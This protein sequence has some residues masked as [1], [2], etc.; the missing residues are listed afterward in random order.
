MVRSAACYIVGSE[1]ELETIRGRIKAHTPPPEE[2]INLACEDVEI[3]TEITLE[4]GGR[5]ISGRMEK[6][7][8]KDKTFRG[9][10][11]QVPV[12]YTVDF[13]FVQLGQLYLIVHAGRKIADEIAEELESIIF[14]GMNGIVKRKEL[15]D[16]GIRRFFKN[17]RGEYV[18]ALG[19]IIALDPTGIP[20]K[21]ISYSTYIVGAYPQELRNT[22]KIFYIMFVTKKYGDLRIS[23]SDDSQVTFYNKKTRT[24]ATVDRPY[25]KTFSEKDVLTL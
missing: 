7:E 3:S 24:K 16:P 5:Q 25:V 13:D 23:V 20:I 18:S 12:P 17:V 2:T 19:E 14:S 21:N 1:I 4:P 22:G 8:I 6:V 9:H 10:P 15:G 11:Y